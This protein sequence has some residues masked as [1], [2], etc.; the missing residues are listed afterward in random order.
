MQ[1]DFVFEKMQVDPE[2]QRKIGKV[3]ESGSVVAFGGSLIEFQ[4]LTLTR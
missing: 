3:R 2:G 4:D 1:N